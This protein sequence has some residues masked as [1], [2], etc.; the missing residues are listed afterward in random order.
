MGG[1]RTPGQFQTN[2]RACDRPRSLLRC[3]HLQESAS[4]SLAVNRASRQ[5]LTRL[6]GK[7][8]M[9]LC[10]RCKSD[11]RMACICCEREAAGNISHLQSGGQRWLRG[12][13]RHLKHVPSKGGVYLG[14]KS[15]KIASLGMEVK[16]YQTETF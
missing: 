4:P 13:C 11:F 3:V 15:P 9:P 2:R 7:D 8:L 14:L 10:A 1:T 6:L 12:K 5:Q 16:P